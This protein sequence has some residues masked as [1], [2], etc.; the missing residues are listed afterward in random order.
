MIVGPRLRSLL[1][2]AALAALAG[3]ASVGRDYQR[4]ETAAPS[5]W[6]SAQPDDRGA[7]PARWWSA[8]HDPALD[9]LVAK[10][11]AANFDAR[12]ATARLREARALLGLAESSQGPNGEISAGAAR[13]RSQFLLPGGARTA[14]VGN[15]YQAGFDAGWE[16]DLFGG[17]RRAVEAAAADLGAAEAG[18]REVLVSVAAEVA[19]AYIELCSAQQRLVIAEATL[20]NQRDH[21][22]LSAARV[23]A[24]LLDEAAL[25]QADAQLATEQT[26]LPSLAAARQRAANRLALLIG[27]PVPRLEEQAAAGPGQRRLV[28]RVR[29]A[30]AAQAPLFEA[31]IVP[32]ALEVL[33]L[34]LPSELLRRR[35]DIQRVERELAAAT[36]RAGIAT[37]EFYPS[38]SLSGGFGFQSLRASD[39]FTDPSHV[40]SIG[41]TVRW[42]LLGEGLERVRA[43]VRAADART[44]Q[45]ALRYEQT[46]LAAFAEVEDTLVTLLR[47]QE[48][49]RA[50]AAAAAAHR[51][52]L[53]LARERQA[54]GIDDF[55]AVLNEELALFQVQDQQELSRATVALDLVAL[56]KALGGGW[57]DQPPAR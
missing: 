25:A 52:A 46:V 8:F 41:P 3:C 40:W 33:R 19:R 37:A 9:G 10:A 20:A 36:A 34:G 18:R 49:V 26:V 13:S 22:E 31:A 43:D 48:R 50:L 5:A 16:L 15:S 23:Q 39:L 55:Q 53:D 24:G 28:A 51:R 14:V 42:P 32:D 4:P 57:E 6:S 2:P 7:A 17:T 1:I 44:E 54:H 27:E 38:F 56:A 45:A 11:L 29:G 12:I 35:P 21:R 47:E 30:E